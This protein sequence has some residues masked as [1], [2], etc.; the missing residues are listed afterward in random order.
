MSPLPGVLR[1][2]IL[3][4][5]GY[6][7]FVIVHATILQSGAGW[8]DLADYPR[9]VVRALGV[10]LLASQLR[11]RKRWAWLVAVG[12][13]AVLAVA[14]AAGLILLVSAGQEA[15]SDLPTAGI[16]TASC[17]LAMLTCSVLL[18]LHRDSRE[19]YR[20]RAG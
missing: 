10:L 8:V 9:A 20:A 14:G 17:A 2:A 7:V 12:G 15:R 16:V 4:L 11:A 6:G 13:G 5:V 3:S 19:V 18:L 1:L